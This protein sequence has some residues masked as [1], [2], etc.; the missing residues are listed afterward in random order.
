MTTQ[1][2][3]GQPTWRNSRLPCRQ[4]AVPPPPSCQCTASSL[5][6]HAWCAAC[7][8][9]IEFWRAKFCDNDNMHLSIMG[10][11]HAVWTSPRSLPYR[12]QHLPHFESLPHFG[13]WCAQGDGGIFPSDWG[14]LPCRNQWHLPHFE[15]LPHFGVWC[16]HEGV[17][18]HQRDGGI[19]PFDWGPV[20]A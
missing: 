1:Q 17:S 14:S 7:G 12:N 4:Y 20:L 13:V 10:A 5:S 15:S 2:V 6:Y 16:A 19:F 8:G 18:F 3:F 9:N 11:H